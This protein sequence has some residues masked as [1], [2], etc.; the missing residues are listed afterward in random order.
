MSQTDNT[1]PMSYIPLPRLDPTA[2][3]DCLRML[4]NENYSA[5]SNNMCFKNVSQR[6][7]ATS[8]RKYSASVLCCITVAIVSIRCL[9]FS[10]DTLAFLTLAL[11]DLVGA[12]PLWSSGCVL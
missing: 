10:S 7:I 4:S 11:C 5:N 6:S 2:T 8:F 12:C 3:Q 9:P 1:S